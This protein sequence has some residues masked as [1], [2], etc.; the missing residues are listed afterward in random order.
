MAQHWLIKL[1]WQC[2]LVKKGVYKDGHDCDDVFKYWNHN[3]LPR[4]KLLKEQMVTY[5]GPK[6]VKTMSVLKEGKK[7]VV[8]CFHDRC[9]MHANSTVSSVWIEKDQQPLRSKNSGQL[10]HISYF[11]TEETGHLIIWDKDGLILKD[12]WQ[13]IFPGLN[14]NPWWDCTQL[15]KQMKSATKIFNKAYPD[16]Q[17]LFI[18][19]Q[20]SAHTLLPPDALCAFKLNCSERGN[21]CTQHNTI[22]PES[23][24][25]SNMQGK[26]QKMR[27]F[28]A[29]VS[30]V[31]ANLSF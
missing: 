7:Q 1:G 4:M 28:P 23:N 13:I 30:Q 9:C 2:S 3:F 10:I 12:T 29:Q 18:F 31:Q 15:I 11:V 19:D 8:P 21:Q 6:Q 22:I 16:C 17:A 26:P 14:S 20:S 24:S 25:N 27:H 5:E